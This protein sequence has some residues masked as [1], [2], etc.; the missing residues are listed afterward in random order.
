MSDRFALFQHE[1]WL[2][3]VD[4]D[5]GRLV[6]KLSNVE[7]TVD[8][9][10]THSGNKY[11]PDYGVLDLDNHESTG[12]Q[13]LWFGR[14]SYEI[15]V[16]WLMSFTDNFISTPRSVEGRFRPVISPTA[17]RDVASQLSRVRIVRHYSRDLHL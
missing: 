11:W 16:D 7:L 8:E 4:V 9:T 6:S 5:M 14:Q 10:T 13:S 2:Y 17:N 12:N 15:S 1:D 3:F